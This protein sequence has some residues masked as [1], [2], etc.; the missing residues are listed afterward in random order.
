MIAAA[1][2]GRIAVAAAGA[3][4]HDQND[5]PPAVAATHTV[6]IKVAH[7][8]YLQAEF[9]ERF[10]AHSMLFRRAK[11]VRPLKKKTAEL[12]AGARKTVKPTYD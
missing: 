10:T 8:E 4:Q 9:S 2:A 12:L 3:Q 5:D 1:G 6:T 7:R 11:K